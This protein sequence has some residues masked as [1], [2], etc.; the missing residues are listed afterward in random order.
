MLSESE[1]GK[2]EGIKKLEVGSE[3]RKEEEN[4]T[5]KEGEKKEE[6]EN[7]TGKEGGKKEEEE[8]QTGKEG[9]KKEEEVIKEGIEE[10]ISKLEESIEEAIKG[11]ES[12]GLKEPEETKNQ[13]EE[14]EVSSGLVSSEE[15]KVPPAAVVQSPSV[16]V[17]EP[18]TKEPLEPESKE[19][20]DIEPSKLSGQGPVEV[21]NTEV[22]TTGQSAVP[23]QVSGKKE[24]KETTKP[25]GIPVGKKV[26]AE[27]PKVPTEQPK[28]PIE[29]SKV[30]T[31]L[32]KPKQIVEKMKQSPLASPSSNNT[33]MTPINVPPSQ[34]PRS[35]TTPSPAP[36]VP[37]PLTPG[38]QQM[39][40]IVVVSSGQPSIVSSGIQSMASGSMS[41]TSSPHN[42]VTVQNAMIQ[43]Q[44]M[45]MGGQGMGMVN[46][47]MMTN[48]GHHGHGS[49]PIQIVPQGTFLSP[50][51]P[52]YIQSPTMFANNANPNLITIQQP[53]LTQ[54]GLSL[55]LPQSMGGGS[56]GGV[57]TSMGGV[58]SNMGGVSTNMGGVNTNLGGVNTLGGVNNN[59]GAKIAMP[60]NMTGMGGTLNTINKPGN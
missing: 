5:G 29:Q 54:G 51:Q 47:S 13:P 57:N 55:Q 27:Q 32:S 1:G 41:F 46:Q 6:E 28:V 14:E 20:K 3:E 40:Q 59:N 23:T 22:G 50:A 12:V 26:P 53:F 37:T 24:A 31:E 45:L 52:M 35:T 36:K 56:V 9:E 34:S 38:G 30:S 49:H 17:Q 10:V 18:L 33:N 39:Q 43:Q 4:Q 16:T 58:N 2:E 11:R 25:L 44:Q 21:S 42:M 8:N 48:P 7:Q 60:K 15:Q 19:S